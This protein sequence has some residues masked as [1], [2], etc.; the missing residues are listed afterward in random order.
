MEHSKPMMVDVKDGTTGEPYR[1][2]FTF[3]LALTRRQAMFADQVRRGLIGPTPEGTEPLANVQTECYILGQLAARVVDS[4][5]W[6]Q[7]SDSGRDLTAYNVVL[8]VY[9]KALEAEENYKKSFAKEAVAATKKLKEKK[10]PD[11]VV[12]ND[13]EE[14]DDAP[15]L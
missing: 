5:K 8:E 3:R 10:K 9:N 12:T 15:T 7:D 2:E 1:G 6:W 14:D 4:P 13:Q 11:T